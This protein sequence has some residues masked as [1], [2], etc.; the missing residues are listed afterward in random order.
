MLKSVLAAI[1]RFI[2][3]MPRYVL[4]KV[5]VAG[6]WV[7]RLVA[8]PAP[9]YEPQPMTPA[10]NRSDEEHLQAIRT[11]AGHLC[12]GDRP[13]MSAMALLSQD[14]V[15]WLGTMTKK[16]QSIVVAASDADLR[17]HLRGKR[18]IRGLLN[19]DPQ[20]VGEYRKAHERQRMAPPARREMRPA[21]A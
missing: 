13:P 9:A 16:M 12:A 7:M 14:D 3:A 15:V 17:A 8:V 19:H 1:S 18:M 21:V 6:E 10:V 20:A 4:Q 11:A 5:R 2:A